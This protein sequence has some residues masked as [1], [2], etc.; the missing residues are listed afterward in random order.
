MVILNARND[1]FTLAELLELSVAIP[2]LDD[3]R[4]QSVDRFVSELH[5]TCATLTKEGIS[6]DFEIVLREIGLRDDVVASAVAAMCS[7]M[8]AVTHH[9]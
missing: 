7:L 8:D 3:V 1:P 4:T 6:V 2:R 5:A 9:E